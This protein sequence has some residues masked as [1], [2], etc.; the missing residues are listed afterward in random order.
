MPMPDFHEISVC[1]SSYKRPQANMA[2]TDA[3]TS[4]LYPNSARALNEAQSKGF[5]NAILEDSEGNVAELDTANL[6]IVK[7]NTAI[8]PSDNGTF[9]CGITR[10]RVKKL[11][12]ENGIT[13]DERK[14]KF[15]EI[16]DAD[17]IFS[18]GNFGKVTPIGIVENKKKPIGTVT[19]T[20]HKLYMEWTKKFP[21]L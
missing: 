21:I 16:L 9:L 13:V 4:C 15:E 14:M 8:T 7:N 3:K 2:P 19:S 12:T 10:N 11:L 20:A 17:E 1:L 18:T 6:W 5:D